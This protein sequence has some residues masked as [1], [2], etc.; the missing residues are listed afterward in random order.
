MQ[1]EVSEGLVPLEVATVTVVRD[2]VVT[3]PVPA[4]MVTTTEMR[5]APAKSLR[6]AAPATTGVGVDRTEERRGENDRDHRSDGPSIHRANLLPPIGP[7]GHTR[8]LI[9]GPSVPPR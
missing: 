4:T 8:H 7:Q 6:R 5:P 2:T 9:Q 3:T 1:G